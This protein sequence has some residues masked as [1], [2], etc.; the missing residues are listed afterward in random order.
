M[1]GWVAGRHESRVLSFERHRCAGVK[2]RGLWVGPAVT[3]GDA[4]S[5]S[6][7]IEI[8]QKLLH[9]ALKRPELKDEL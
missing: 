7:R 3:A 1:A 4:P 2:A 6:Q 8:A 5:T 9:N